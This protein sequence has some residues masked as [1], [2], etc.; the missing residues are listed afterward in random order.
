MSTASNRDALFPATSIGRVPRTPSHESLTTHPLLAPSSPQHDP[1]STPTI[2]SP[3]VPYT[4][5]QRVSPSSTTTGTT[6][7]SP[8]VTASPPHQHQGD[9]T[10]KLQ[11]MNLKAAAQNMGLDTT[12]VGWLILDTLVG[13]ADNGPEWNEVWNAITNGKATL[14][15]PT[16]QAVPSTKCTPA[17]VKDHIVYREEKPGDRSA[18]VTLSGLRGYLD[19]PSPYPSFTISSPSSP[20]SLPPR[21]SLTKPPL[22]PRPGARPAPASV[23]RLSNPFASLFGHKQP[24]SPNPSNPPT[25][26][27]P[28]TSIDADHVSE[29]SALAISH[30]VVFKDIGKEINRALRAELKESLQGIPASVIER[31]HQ[32]SADFY[33]LIKASRN[34][35]PRKAKKAPQVVV[36]GTPPGASP[37]SSSMLVVNPIQETP[38]DLCERFQDFYAS[39]EEDLRGGSTPFL[40][41]KREDQSQSQ[42][43]PE[44][45]PQ[46]VDSEAKVMEIMETIERTICS[47]FYD[48]I[49][50][51]PTSDDASHDEALS[52]R[53]AA[54][55]MLD[56]GLE[57]L[58]I[59][60]GDMS[61]ELNLVVK[62]CGETLTQLD[63]AC[64][65]P[66]DKAA[67]LVAAHKIV[68]D[69]LSRL[70]PIRLKSQE[71]AKVASALPT[72]ITEKPITGLPVTDSP[73]PL[74]QEPSSTLTTPTP[75]AEESAAAEMSP[76]I[77]L[78]DADAPS[79][80]ED[81]EV[82]ED[83][84]ASS[85]VV[86]DGATPQPSLPPSPP[87]MDEPARLSFS[88]EPRKAPTPVSGDV[89]L[90]MIIFSVVKANPPHLVSHLLFTQRFRNQSIGG[91]ESYCLINLLAVAE[92]L[93]NVDLAALGLSDTN[94]VMSTA[95]LTPLPVPRSP[96]VLTPPTPE[97]AIARLEEIRGKVGQSV[98]A[99]NKVITGVV[100]S[101]FTILRS[102]I[103]NNPNSPLNP[104]PINAIPSPID[105]AHAGG[106]AGFGLLRRQSS[107]FSLA[108]IAASLPIPGARSKLAQEEN[109]QPLLP[110]SRPASVKSAKQTDDESSSVTDDTGDD[111]GE[112]EDD[113]GEEGDGEPI[114]M[115]GGSLKKE[116][117][118]RS[119]R[120]FESMM[121]ERQKNG[122]S[123]SGTGRKSL[124]DRLASVSGM[125]SLKGS[126]PSRR[127]SILPPSYTSGSQRLESP[128][129]SGP[130]SPAGSLRLA[131]PNERF[132]SCSDG[133]LKILEV[134]EL[135][136]D[137][138]RLVN[139]IRAAGGFVE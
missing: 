51:Q 78:S 37:S 113:D 125:G 14:L 97:V 88:P 72:P 66:G 38:E 74:V 118:A 92:F 33:P 70:P 5:R 77:I 111:S 134:A 119:I 3:Y 64:R 43:V 62:A 50:M 120:S 21:A 114:L 52:G 75:G 56:L 107:G 29:I 17:F 20:L 103:T 31:V 44:A 80:A 128:V 109:G 60:V 110:V 101:S 73:L 132:M 25:P 19:G 39:L 90:P 96:S 2:S 47:L 6:V 41:R 139:G 18:V 46:K 1:N 54:L 16:E 59:V 117:D 55:N 138:R 36:E 30:K 135:L 126:P 93:E 28:P 7:Q 121:S 15:L 49:F 86:A 122:R 11:L 22:P 23:S 130:P 108:S 105:E 106:R 65:S 69:G 40:S 91:E 99:A 32:F 112:D 67:V 42:G 48:R 104:S 95:D 123:R 71:E 137:Y 24:P 98:D 12:S 26:T 76:K 8:V 115:G 27:P 68:V 10:S 45:T 133:D 87:K 4:P 129:Y 127:P 57:H 58:D 94:K 85:T 34:P 124:T 9:A 102:I 79:G 13:E 116:F 35:S 81:K 84:P 100:D 136:K 89:L 61:T 53:V 63:V 83:A 82:L 131:P